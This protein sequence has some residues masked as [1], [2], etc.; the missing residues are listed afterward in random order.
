MAFTEG[1]LVAAKSA[2]DAS[3]EDVDPDVASVIE[4]ELGASATKSADRIREHC[5]PRRFEAQGS[6]SQQYARLSGRRYYGGCSR[7]LRE[8]CDRRDQTVC[9]TFAN[10]QPQSVRRRMPPLHAMLKQAKVQGSISPPAG[11]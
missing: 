4:Q 5:Q 7:R 1:P 10:V 2:F 9:A 8:D 11:I 3:L 6:V